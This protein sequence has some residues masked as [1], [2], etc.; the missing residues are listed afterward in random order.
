M[1]AKNKQNEAEI[2]KLK[3]EIGHVRA[4][5][6]EPMPTQQE[7]DNAQPIASVQRHEIE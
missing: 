4:S 5:A 6:N 7:I 3:K 1:G 2:Q